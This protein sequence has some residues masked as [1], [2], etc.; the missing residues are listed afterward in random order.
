MSGQERSLDAL[1]RAILEATQAGLPLVAAPYAEIAARVG[2]PES[3]EVSLC[4]GQT[5]NILID[6]NNSV[7]P[8]LG[9]VAGFSWFLTLSPLPSGWTGTPANY[10]DY[11][12][13]TG[14]AP[15]VYALPLTNNGQ[16]PAGVYYL[17]PVLVSGANPIAG[18]D[19]PLALDGGCFVFGTPILV[20]VQPEFDPINAAGTV[21]PE[22]APP[23]NNGAIN[24]SVGGGSEAYSFEWSNGATTQNQTGLHAGSY[25]VTI[26]DA[27]GCV[28]TV[29]SF[30]VPF[31]VATENIPGV[32][33]ISAMPNPTSG[34]VQFLVQLTENQPVS[35]RLVN[36][37][38]QNLA[39]R[40]FAAGEKAEGSFDLANQPGG[41]FFLRFEVGSRTV[42]R[43]I[44]LVK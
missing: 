12:G 11:I 1:D 26:I 30:V 34:P 32:A 43:K 27:T 14:L 10:Q 42:E 35:V 28:E 21:T 13:A 44:V 29:K 9:P 16:T 40:K 38:G 5:L 36:A 23:G 22:T 39:T 41:V 2:A 31:V 17:T 25:T 4:F 6:E 19:D 20:T 33:S 3:E 37:L 8:N 24:L 7:V 15:I 18:A